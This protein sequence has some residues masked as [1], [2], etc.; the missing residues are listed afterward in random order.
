[1]TFEL[2]RTTEDEFP[3][4]IRCLEDA[5]GFHADEENVVDIRA[6][7]EIDRTVAVFDGDDI[8]GTAGAYTFELTVPGDTVVP[9][10]GVTAVTVRATHR[11]RGILRSMMASQLDD[12]A[13][14]GEP[15]AILT[16]SES[17]IYG[18]FGY[19]LASLGASWTIETDHA[20]LAHPARGGG[21]MRLSDKDELGA[22]APAI[23]DARR[24]RIPGAVNR[25]EAW[26]EDWLKD[27]E[28]TRGG[29]SARW[30][31]LHESADGEVDGFIG[32][33][34][35]RD[36]AHGLSRNVL[37]VDQLFGVDDEVE[38]AL[39]AFAF[40]HDLIH[41]V[42]AHGRPVDEPIRW[43]LADPRRLVT[44]D[45]T[46]DLWLRV[47][48]VG[49]ALSARRYARDDRFTI[50]VHDAFRPDTSG[51]YLVD[52]GPEGATCARS[53]GEPDLTMGIADLGAIYLGG[54]T[55]TSLWRAGRIVEATEGAVRR[56][57]AFFASSPIPWMTTGF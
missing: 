40:E 51:R 49:G 55:P 19:G 11:R 45:V 52:G 53:D 29:Q 7:T 37:T 47:V 10:A 16:A 22:H 38:A 44:T 17:L 35:N 1:M 23:Y 25:V 24:R 54:A 3:R 36:N 57:D 56:A 50:E 32:Y 6:S 8:V 48:D 43:R 39:W 42:A 34:R 33:R 28:W 31:A 26:W 4:Y 21:R 13:E 14:R 41:S 12:V 9:A 18:R 30:Y 2:R 46:D 27:R 20:A 5:F 15:I